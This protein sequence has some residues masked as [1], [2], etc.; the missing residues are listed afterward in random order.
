MT[1]ADYEQVYQLWSDTKGMGMRSL[2][3]SKLGIEKFL[4]RNPN[5]NFVAVKNGK[6]IG[7]T[8]SGH[9]GR[10]GCIYHT[11]VK[12]EF[13]GQGIGKALIAAVC[14]AMKNEGINKLFLVAFKTN[15][16]GNAFWQSQNWELRTDLNYCN[17]NL[18]TE[19][20]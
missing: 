1:I 11:A 17:K 13:R 6:I 10:R 3:D 19:N 2:D 9:D 20:K 5:T 18:N 8:L 14:N 12:I 4:K 7:I 16:K 15:E